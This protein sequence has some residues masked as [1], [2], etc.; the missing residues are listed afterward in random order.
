MPAF[1]PCLRVVFLDKAIERENVYTEGGK[2]KK[3]MLPCRS[4]YPQLVSDL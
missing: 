3:T 1:G 2:K 4:L